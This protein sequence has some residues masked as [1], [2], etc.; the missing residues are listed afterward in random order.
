MKDYVVAA[1]VVCFLAGAACF[2]VEW[3]I[4]ARRWRDDDHG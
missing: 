3:L 4:R 2:G 1:I